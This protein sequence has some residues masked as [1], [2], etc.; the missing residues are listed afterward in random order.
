MKSCTLLISFISLMPLG[1]FAFDIPAKDLYAKILLANIGRDVEVKNVSEER[2]E[3]VVKGSEGTSIWGFNKDGTVEHDDYSKDGRHTSM[4]L[5]NNGWSFGMQFEPV[6]EV[7]RPTKEI[8][9]TYFNV[10]SHFNLCSPEKELLFRI[11]RMNIPTE[12]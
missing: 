10:K 3:I 12:D 2:V 11:D 5:N 6:W 1:I 9:F 7:S 8:V 4:T